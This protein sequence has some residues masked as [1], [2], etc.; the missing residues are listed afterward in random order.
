M[1]LWR[2]I[3]FQTS[4]ILWRHEDA[5]HAVVVVGGGVAAAGKPGGSAPALPGRHL[6]HQ[7]VRWLAGRSGKPRQPIRMHAARPPTNQNAEPTKRRQPIRM[8]SRQNATYAFCPTQ[9]KK[10][11]SLNKNRACHSWS[12]QSPALIITFLINCPNNP[13]H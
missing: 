11:D 9:L 5:Q 6:P 12:I 2:P 10:A 7:R 3:F 13:F 1:Y 8:Q 4:G